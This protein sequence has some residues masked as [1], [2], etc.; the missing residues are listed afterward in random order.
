ML[1]E[2]GQKENKGHGVVA[3]GWQKVVQQDKN[4]KRKREEG[5]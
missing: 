3:K 2:R 1:E 5:R 4:K